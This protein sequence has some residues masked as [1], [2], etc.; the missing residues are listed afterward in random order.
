MIEEFTKPIFNRFFHFFLKPHL[1]LNLH[2]TPLSLYFPAIHL[3][4]LRFTDVVRTTWV[5]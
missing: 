3:T 4:I 1:A 2:K 5:G